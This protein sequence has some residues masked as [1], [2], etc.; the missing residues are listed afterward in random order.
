MAGT[1]P[2]EIHASLVSPRDKAAPQPFAGKRSSHDENEDRLAGGGQPGRIATPYI[3]LRA[4]VKNELKIVESMACLWNNSR[5]DC[6]LAFWQCRGS[7]FGVILS[8][9]AGKG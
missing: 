7:L 8:S 5:N 3:N 9:Q 6:R 4:R 2:A 1:S